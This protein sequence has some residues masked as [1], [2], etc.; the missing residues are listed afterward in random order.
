MKSVPYFVD[1][2]L[3]SCSNPDTFSVEDMV[4]LLWTHSVH[5]FVL[6]DNCSGRQLG[7]EVK[8]RLLQQL[9]DCFTCHREREGGEGV[10]NKLQAGH[11]VGLKSRTDV[12]HWHDS[13]GCGRGLIPHRMGHYPPVMGLRR[14]E[15]AY[16]R[17]LCAILGGVIF[18]PLHCLV[19]HTECIGT[20]R[21]TFATSP[22]FR[23]LLCSWSQIVSSL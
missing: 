9:G 20:T 14:R 2:L 8:N 18:R 10:S 15:K 4:I 13:C 22:L 16:L 19:I 1:Q 7:E 5:L 3:D 23:H 17:W 21:D 6:Y 12:C 11:R